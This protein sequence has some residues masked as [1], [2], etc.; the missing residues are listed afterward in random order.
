MKS[1]SRDD[2]EPF[3][4]FFFTGDVTGT[5]APLYLSS[6]KSGKGKCQTAQTI[7]AGDTGK[8]P[9]VGMFSQGINFSLPH[10]ANT[11]GKQIQRNTNRNMPYFT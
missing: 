1:Q 3:F 4:F 6:V 5:A 2:S 8:L 11:L 9:P 7:T 10:S